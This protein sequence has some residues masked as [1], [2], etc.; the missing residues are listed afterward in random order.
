VPRR[1]IL[2]LV[3][4]ALAVARAVPSRAET[5]P[6]P[7]E[8]RVEVVRDTL[9]G[10]VI[11]D[12]YRWLEDQES[13]ATREWIEAQNGYRERVL[14]A[15]PSA[16]RI[17]SRLERLM[18]IESR[19]VPVERGG[20]YFYTRRRADQELAVICMRRGLEGAEEVLVDPHPLSAE[21]TTSVGILDVSDD[22]RLLAYSTRQ[23]GEDEVVVTFLDLE[24]RRELPD[25]LPKGRYFGVSITHDRSGLYYARHT[26]AGPRVFAH[27]FGEEAGRDSMVFGEGYGVETIMS[28]ALSSDGRYLLITV[29]HGSAADRSE[30]YVQDL[31][32]GEAI[33]P[34]VNDLH[35]SFTARFAGDRL[36]VETDW[37]APNRRIL[38]VEPA[39]PARERWR[40]VVPEGPN[41]IQ[42]FTVAGGK[43]FV[44][45]FENALS[46]VKIFDGSG[47]P[48]GSITFATLGALGGVSG[49]WAKDEAFFTFASFHVPTTIY[50]YE[51]ATRRRTE[52]WKP[53]VPVASD[54][55]EV[56]LVWYA[57]KDRTRVP[58]FLVHRKDLRRDGNNPTLLTGYGGFNLSQRPAFSA[59]AALWIEEG[60]V[61]ALPCLRGGGEFGETWH[62]AGMRERKQ[63]VF[64]DFIAAAQ[65]LMDKG[66]TRPE[67]LAISGRSN[68][69]LLVGAALTQRPELFRAVVCGVP[70]LDMLR[71][72]RFLVAR[73][74]VPEYGSPA[75]PEHFAAL[76]AYS[77]YHRVRHGERYPA[78]LF[79]TGD[80]DTR[81]APLHA[82][83]M[84]ALLQAASA[85]GRPVL[86]R[87]DTR[88]GHVS[89]LP[90]SREIE[91]LAGE[92]QFL[93]WQLGV[94]GA[95]ASTPD[96]GSR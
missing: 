86:L 9:H 26:P 49:E 69:G 41:A 24:S 68:G 34:I 45:Y 84:A 28:P 48:E 71:Y 37:Q 33:V 81:V 13:P 3:L 44:N 60:G 40:V 20:A 11:E 10:V 78:V 93:F 54:R 42:G 31:R 77:P 66:Y 57:S 74:W 39:A 25:R 80:S 6:P 7:P 85:S 2:P 21:H 50:R 94:D 59:R 29:A 76:R 67:R 63:N 61:F 23:G 72:H 46:T 4:A 58:M 18:K 96:A 5:V 65:W 19:G 14:A 51:V 79:Y 56:K 12:P 95:L 90:V 17:R 87:Y 8:T 16:E 82:R 30:L 22:G 75:D 52:W 88:F 1:T 53:A 27:A 35:A 43:L 64:D 89:G 62:K 70:L 83:K 91:D 32:S 73:Y 36:F 38:A 92:L 55:F 47:K 15:A